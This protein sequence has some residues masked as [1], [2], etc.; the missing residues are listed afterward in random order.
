MVKVSPSLKKK[1]PKQSRLS[2]K[3]IYKE[4]SSREFYHL[5]ITDELFNNYEDYSYKLALLSRPI[6]ECEFTG[7]S[8]LTYW[9][10]KELEQVIEALVIQRLPAN[11]RSEFLA[12]PLAEADGGTLLNCQDSC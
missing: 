9:Q 8:H 3:K 7:T 5:H 2:Q 6:W 4:K 10:A 12:P 1:I 11:L